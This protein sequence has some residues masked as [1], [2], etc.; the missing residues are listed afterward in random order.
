M[1][2]VIWIILTLIAHHTHSTPSAPLPSASL[3]LLLNL[4]DVATVARPLCR[5]IAGPSS[6]L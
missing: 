5:A 2:N 1:G 6:G 4:Y 3:T